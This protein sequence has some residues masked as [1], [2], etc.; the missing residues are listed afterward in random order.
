[1]NAQ[2]LI[3][4]HHEEWDH[5]SNKDGDDGFFGKMQEARKKMDAKLVEKTVPSDP[6][7]L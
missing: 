4:E 3:E 5:Q 1:M 6:D 2:G 7:K